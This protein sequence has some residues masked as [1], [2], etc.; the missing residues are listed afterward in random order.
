[1]RLAAIVAAAVVGVTAGATADASARKQKPDPR[2]DYVALGDSIPRGTGSSTS[3]VKL[4][5]RLMANE[6]R[7]NVAVKNLS[8]NGASSGEVLGAVRRDRS[9]RRALAGAEVITVSLGLND[10]GGNQESFVDGECGGADNEECYRSSLRRFTANWTAL[11]REIGRLR[12]G[13]RTI[14]RTTTDYNLLVGNSRAAQDFGARYAPLLGVWKRHLSALNREKCAIAA[15][16]GVQCADVHAAF[17]ATSGDE[18]AFAKGLIAA[19]R[20]HPS[21]RGHGVIAGLLRGLGYAPLR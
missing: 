20:I 9:V 16:A 1:V 18:S 7:V 19:D 15:A 4:F 13:K 21:A 2:W 5:G 8:R 14:I 6:A 12:A 3:F 10:F 17:H 11:I